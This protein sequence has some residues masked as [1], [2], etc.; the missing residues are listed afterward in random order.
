M[1][2]RQSADGRQ[3]LRA[4]ERRCVSLHRRFLLQLFRLLTEPSCHSDGGEA[5]GARSL[6]HLIVR[7]CVCVCLREREREGERERAGKQRQR[8]AQERWRDGLFA[9]ISVSISSL[10][11]Q[12]LCRGDCRHFATR[13]LLSLTLSHTYTHKLGF[14]DYLHTLKAECCAS[15]ARCCRCCRGVSGV[16]EMGIH[17]C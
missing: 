1:R 14:S 11:L 12:L 8:V 6:R 17:V 5:R 9:V 3:N 16:Y 4:C 13:A 15:V 10:V 7:V 2:A